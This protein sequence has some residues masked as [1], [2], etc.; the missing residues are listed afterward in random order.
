MDSKKRDF[1]ISEL[2]IL[3][4]GASVQRAKLYGEKDPSDKK[5][6]SAQN[7]FREDIVSFLIGKI[8]PQYEKGCSEQQHYTNIEALIDYANKVNPGILGSSG[9]KYGI[10]QKL[11]NLAL[12]YYW[13][14]GLIIEPHHCP[15]DRIIINKT[16]YSGKTNWTQI[17][18][19]HEYEKIINEIKLL[20]KKDWVSVPEWELSVYNNHDR[21]YLTKM[22]DEFYI[23]EPYRKAWHENPPHQLMDSK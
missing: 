6:K 23:Y 11:L 21:K 22:V 3:A 18:H 15:I 13:C 12:K 14:L 17:L 16:K 8:I 10:A 7:K 20:A 1:V 2:W 5:F 4:W 19:R 9:Y